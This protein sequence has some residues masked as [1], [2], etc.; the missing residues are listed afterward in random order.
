[1]EARDYKDLEIS[2]QFTTTDI[3]VVSE[4]DRLRCFWESLS[5]TRIRI[6][7]SLR[8]YNQSR[9]SLDRVDAARAPVDR[10]LRGSQA[11]AKEQL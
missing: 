7:R 1:M 9:E 4:I 8:A 6:K 5:E 10:T 3:M 2:Q 11:S